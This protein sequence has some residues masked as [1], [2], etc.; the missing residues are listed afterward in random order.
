MRYFKK[1]GEV[2]LYLLVFL[3]PLQTRLII[4]PGMVNFGYL[5][6]GTISLYVTDIILVVLLSFLALNFLWPRA[7]KFLTINWFSPQTKTDYAKIGRAH[8]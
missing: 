2:L 7:K 5:E 8:V 6:Y 1:V 4:R 3:L